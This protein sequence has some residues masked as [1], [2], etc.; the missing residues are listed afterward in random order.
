MGVATLLEAKAIILIVSGAAK[1]KMLRRTLKEPMTPEVP[2]SFLRMAGDR[3][4]VILDEDA[5]A[6]LG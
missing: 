1:A 6:D 3:L 2:A 4:T 5:A